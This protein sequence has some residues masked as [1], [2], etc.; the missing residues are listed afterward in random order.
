MPRCL[1]KL[2]PYIGFTFVYKQ[3]ILV[4]LDDFHADFKVYHIHH[5]CNILLI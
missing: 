2:L 5:L 4:K 3:L 1:K